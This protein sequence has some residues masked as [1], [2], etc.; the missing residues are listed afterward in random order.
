MVEALLFTETRARLKASSTHILLNHLTCVTLSARASMELFIICGSQRPESVMYLFLVNIR[1]CMPFLGRR[2]TR[3]IL[4]TVNF[5]IQ[6]VQI[7]DICTESLVFLD[8]D[9]FQEARAEESEDSENLI[10]LVF[11]PRSL[12]FGR[13]GCVPKNFFFSISSYQRMIRR[14]QLY[15]GIRLFLFHHDESRSTCT[16]TLN[17][18]GKQALEFMK[19]NGSRKHENGAWICLH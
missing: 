12:A 11:R 7:G 6:H 16:I 13:D 4:A 18:Y 14:L 8:R 5:I 1:Q 19:C 3:H 2:G 10:G 15:S 17:V 9:D